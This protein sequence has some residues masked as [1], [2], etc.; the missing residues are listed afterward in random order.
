[1]TSSSK[2]YFAKIDNTKIKFKKPQKTD[3]E[4]C[5]FIKEQFLQGTPFTGY[6]RTYAYKKR[7]HKNQRKIKVVLRL[8]KDFFFQFIEIT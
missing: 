6:L 3:K 5:H 4:R 7:L 8:I 1:M 2:K